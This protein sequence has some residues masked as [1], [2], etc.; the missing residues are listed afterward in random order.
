MII[1]FINGNPVYKTRTAHDPHT[2]QFT[3]GGSSHGPTIAAKAA[4][5]EAK[6]KGASDAEARD[7]SLKAYK[8]A[9]KAEASKAESKLGIF[10]KKDGG[11]GHHTI[12]LTDGRQFTVAHDKAVVWFDTSKHFTDSGAYL[13]KT[14][15][16]AL[17]SLTKRPH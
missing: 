6:A 8:K 7:I 13:G 15:L 14:K 16:E 5:T 11:E 2:G 17:Q 10:K 1:G 3:S 4:H 12:H 9:E